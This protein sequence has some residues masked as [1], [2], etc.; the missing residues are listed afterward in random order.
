MMLLENTGFDYFD[1]GL[2]LFGIN[3]LML[4]V[5]AYDK[6]AARKGGWR[7][8]EANLLLLA[9]LGGSPA[10]W[11][12]MRWFRH[13]SSKRSFRMKYYALV[14]TQLVVIGFAMAM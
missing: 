11:M 12:A 14:V 5:M 1:A 8:P 4:L 7:V 13:K 9:L 2:A 6:L 3:A 10:L